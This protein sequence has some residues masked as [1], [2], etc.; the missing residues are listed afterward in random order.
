MGVSVF[1]AGMRGAKG[2]PYEGGTRVPSFWRWPAGWKG[3]VDVPALTAHL[4]IFPT[5]AQIAGAKIPEDVAAKLDGHDLLPLL[6]NPAAE[7]PDRILI[8]HVGRWKHGEAAQAKYEKC[9]ARDSRFS[10]VNNTALYDLIA[11]P[12]Q[13]NNVAAQYPAETEKL[14]TAYDKWWTEILPDLVNEDAVGPKENP[15]KERYRSQFGGG[16]ATQ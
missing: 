6:K 1:N 8:T 10:L 16:P 13:K 12:E 4:D 9:A 3:G 15:F 14:R 7:W 5:L 11:D 2:T